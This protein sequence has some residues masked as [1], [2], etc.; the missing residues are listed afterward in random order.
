M[1]LD[2]ELALVAQQASCSA[3][4]LTPGLWHR[5]QTCQF[6]DLQVATQRRCRIRLQG[7]S[8]RTYGNITI[9]MW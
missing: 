2:S 8:H 9:T 3:P 7:E 1:S 5:L 6:G 4:L